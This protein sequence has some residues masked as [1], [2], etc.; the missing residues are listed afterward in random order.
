MAF[1]EGKMVDQIR[2]FIAVE[3][4]AAERRAFGDLQAELKKQP[5][6]RYVRWVAPESIHLTLKFLGGVD[7]GMVAALERAL[8]EASQGV[9]AFTLSLGGLGAFPNTRRPNVVWVGLGGDVKAAET[10][11]ENIERACE[12]LGF[13]R[14][15]RPFAAHLTLGRVKRDARPAD[16]QFVGEMVAQA[17]VGDLG[18]IQANSV[19]LMKS[20]LTP[21]GSIYTR[22]G[23]VELAAK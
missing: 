5:A 4:D 21:S 23:T 13:A 3:L 7:P 22:L 12:A 16:R 2:T 15:S 17:H 11:T 8:V 9:T 6:G 14:E 1:T 18:T 19:S 20:D 10:L